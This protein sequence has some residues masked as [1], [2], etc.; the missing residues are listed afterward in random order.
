MHTN[1]RAA[2]AALSLVLPTPAAAQITVTNPME[3]PLGISLTREGSGTSSLPDDS[4]TY[5]WHRMTGSWMLMRHDNTF[6]QYVRDGSDRGSNQF[7][8]TN[9]VM[10]M[11]RHPLGRVNMAPARGFRL[12]FSARS[13]SGP[14]FPRQ[15]RRG[16]DRG[17]PSRILR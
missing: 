8:S 4:P 13:T 17:A 7:G 12:G 14:T 9:W 11:A 5:A 1:T 3:S 10:G 6:V 15:G 2:L 16:F